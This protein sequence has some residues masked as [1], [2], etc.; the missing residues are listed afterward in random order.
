MKEES[1]QA[2]STGLE[3]QISS[4]ISAS[5]YVERSCDWASLSVFDITNQEGSQVPSSFDSKVQTTTFSQAITAANVVISQRDHELLLDHLLDRGKDEQHAYLLCGLMETRGHGRLLVR[6]IVF[7]EPHDLVQQTP[8]FLELS[9][10]YVLRVLDRARDENLHIIEAHSHPFHHGPGVSFSSIDIAGELERFPWYATEMPWMRPATLVFG[11]DSV[12]GHWWNPNTLRLEAIE[13]VTVVGTRFQK[14]ITTSNARWNLAGRH[15]SETYARQEMAL[16]SA[17]QAAIRKLRVGIVG[18]GGLGSVFCQQFA[19]LGVSEIVVVDPDTVEHSNLNRLIFGRPEDAETSIPKVDVM[20]RGIGEVRPDISVTAIQGS[21]VEPAIQQSLKDV[22]LLIAA[23]DCDGAR[24]VCGQLATRYLIPLFDTGSG[25]QV[26]EG[27]VTAMGGQC[28]F[29]APGEACIACSGYIDADKARIGLMTAFE[30]ERHIE[31]GYGT[32]EK[33]PA[34]LFLNSVVVSLAM[35][36]I[37]KYITNLCEPNQVTFYDGLTGQAQPC[38]GPSRQDDCPACHRSGLYGR[39]DE[40]KT[41]FERGIP[42]ALEE[43]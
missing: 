21:I 37:V 8:T 33:Q 2:K 24:L 29:F 13:A 36:E 5:H 17:G 12:D 30:R 43:I 28:M 32:G 23:T 41:R 27:S 25:V 38:A 16:G 35:A 22:D 6:D 3:G 39:G 14:R 7:A 9:L 31:R 40:D 20:R 42:I 15:E 34:V 19:Y 10:D 18:A 1:I 26:L 4:K 11:H